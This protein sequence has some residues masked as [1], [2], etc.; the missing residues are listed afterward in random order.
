MLTIIQYVPSV[1]Y[2]LV[3]LICLVMARKGIFAKR[4]IPFHEK[5]A[6]KSWEEL[7]ARIKS[8]ILSLTRTTGLGF[9]AVGLLMAAAAIAS[10]GNPGVFLR[11]GAPLIA[12]LY[13]TGLFWATYRLY[14]AA[15]TETPWRKSLVAMGLLVAGLVV[16]ILE[17]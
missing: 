13:C 9:L 16:S 8:V 12:L 15:G 10:L 3:T 1:L 11:F 7:E 4:F 6:G 2:L 5:A 14:R 17:G